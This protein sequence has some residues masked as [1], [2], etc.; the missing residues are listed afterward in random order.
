MPIINIQS[1][2]LD[3]ENPSPR[4]DL[5]SQDFASAL[6]IDEQHLS[7]GWQYFSSG[8]YRAKSLGG[9]TQ[10]PTQPIQVQ[11]LV[12]DFTPPERRQLM[13]TTLAMCISKHA[14]LPL[15]Q[16]FIYLQ[17]VASGEVFDD[18]KLATW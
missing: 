13:L 7:I 3:L 14:G 12:P 16:I 4:L 6:A 9:R 10:G 15:N 2:P 18:G 11:L 5:I 8:C 1:L 17:T